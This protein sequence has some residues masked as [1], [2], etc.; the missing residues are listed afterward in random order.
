MSLKLKLP[1]SEIKS[2][3]ISNVYYVPKLDYNLLSVTEITK[4]GY[5]VAF[6]DSSCKITDQNNLL[7][8]GVKVGKLFMLCVHKLI[9]AKSVLTDN[10]ENDMLWHRRFCHLNMDYL[11]KLI[12]EDTPR[13]V[14]CKISSSK[15]LCESCCEGKIQR[16]PFPTG[17]RF[18]LKPLDLIHSD[19]CGKITPDSLGGGLYFVTFIDH[20]TRYTWVYILKN[21]NDVFSKFKEF[22]AMVERQY[23]RKIKTLRTDNGGE[24]TSHIFERF[25]TN[26]G[27]RHERSIAKTPEQN[28]LAER[29]NR[30]LVETV[31]CMISDS[32]VSKI[33]WAEAI[34]TAT[35]IRNRSPCSSLNLKTPYEML[36]GRK[37]NVKHIR[38][39][40][41]T[42]FAHIPNDERKKLDFKA[43]K[44]I[45]VGYGT[46]TKGYRLY[47]LDWRRI[48]YSKDVIFDEGNYPVLNKLSDDETKNDF[49]IDLSSSESSDEVSVNEPVNSIRKSVRNRKEPD[50]FGEWA[51]IASDNNDPKTVDEALKSSESKFWKQ[52]MERE[53]KALS[54]N[55]V[56]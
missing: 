23:E 55:K 39:F 53:L 17:N 10:L 44:C 42:A 8:V 16:S 7:A 18:N 12:N 56:C 32:G 25:L 1:N 26:E 54:D 45:I 41:C 50:R 19:V 31:R 34:S 49:K 5:V 4:K 15:I 30:T 29:M 47:D 22:K 6:T 2:C 9:A 24:Y 33:F 21:K 13:G 43:R 14:N 36:N 38:I 20:A 48:I 37:S 35:Y 28:G 52:A 11:R 46:F 3:T 27:I 51:Y 40:G